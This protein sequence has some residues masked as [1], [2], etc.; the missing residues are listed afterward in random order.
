MA[1]T[2]VSKIEGKIKVLIKEMHQID[3]QSPKCTHGELRK[4]KLIPLRSK[5]VWLRMLLSIHRN[6]E[7]L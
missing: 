3:V 6:M 5:L 4:E 7:Y 1:K 2:K